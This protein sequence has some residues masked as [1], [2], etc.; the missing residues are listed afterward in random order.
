MNTF[1]KS[2]SFALVVV[3][4]AVAAT[5][6]AGAKDTLEA[7]MARVCKNK[8]LTES[9]AELRVL[10]YGALKPWWTGTSVK[11]EFNSFVVYYTQSLMYFI[12]LF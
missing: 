4:L 5:V 6:D 2:V 1:Q 3:A 11:F 12:A 8:G 7:D 10:A 9:L